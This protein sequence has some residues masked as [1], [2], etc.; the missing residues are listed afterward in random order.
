MCGS[1]ALLIPTT[2]NVAKVDQRESY[3]GAYLSSFDADTVAGESDGKL[4]VGDLQD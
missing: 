1:A 3:C 4:L 2:I